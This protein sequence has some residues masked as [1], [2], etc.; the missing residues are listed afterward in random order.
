MRD[1]KSVAQDNLHVLCLFCMLKTLFFNCS[2]IQSG[3]CNYACKFTRKKL[4]VIYEQVLN[5]YVLEYFID[6]LTSRQ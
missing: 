6:S 5:Y 2:I 3:D 1:H 4:F